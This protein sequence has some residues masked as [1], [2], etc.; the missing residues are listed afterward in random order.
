MVYW[1]GLVGAFRLVVIV[2]VYCGLVGAFRLVVIG[3]CVDLL[4]VHGI[5]I[6][7]TRTL[8]C[9]VKKRR[10]PL[11]LCVGGVDALVSF[12][13]CEDLF[14]G[15]IYIDVFGVI[16]VFGA[17]RA[18]VAVAVR[19]VDDGDLFRSIVDEELADCVWFACCDVAGAGRIALW[20]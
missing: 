15:R 10:E 9:F 4:A 5:F 11:F 20:W 12:A 17:R 3:V 14:W 18:D 6:C 19:V 1:C 13:L 8:R 16:F 7:G 2:E